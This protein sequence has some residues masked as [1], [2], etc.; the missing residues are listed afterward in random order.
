[1]GG[2]TPLLWLFLVE[3]IKLP[4]NTQVFL[5]QPLLEWRHAF[6]LFGSLGLV[7]TALFALWF[8]NRPQEKASVNEAERNLISA[9]RKD[10][11]GAHA[12]VPWR[13]LFSNR[14]LWCLCLMY[15][16]GSYGWYFNISYLPTFLEQQYDVERTSLVGALYKGGPLWMGAL[17]CL[18]GGFLTDR[19]IRRTG[20]QKWGRRLFG[21]V[22]HGL[23]ALC[24]LSCLFMPSA[25]WF[26]LAISLAAFWN[27][28]TMGSAWATCQDIGKRYAAIVAGCMNT[29]GNLGG[30]A[31]NL[32]TGFIVDLSL[33]GH[34]AKLQVD[35]NTLSPA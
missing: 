8:C 4:G 28:M 29:I 12:G 23:C 14:N 2:L 32:L 35:V 5:T 9:C 21:V 16:C 31:A 25:F 7:W 26:F 10:E 18:V 30:A 27:D 22:G 24:Y 3:G 15:F 33:A 19:V 34:A 17:A 20:N 11:G 6:W 13:K 1:M